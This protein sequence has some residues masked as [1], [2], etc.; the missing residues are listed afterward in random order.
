MKTSNIRHECFLFANK[1][2]ELSDQKLMISFEVFDPSE[3][4][5]DMQGKVTIEEQAEAENVSEETIREYELK[6]KV[7]RLK[8]MGYEITKEGE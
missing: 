8:E 5:T 6:A 4:A 1:M 7:K 2:M 3:M